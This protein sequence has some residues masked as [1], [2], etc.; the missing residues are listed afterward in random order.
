[1]SIITFKSNEQKETAQT[2]SIAAVATQLAIERNYK[3]L[4]VSTSFKDKTLED[5]FWESSKPMAVEKQVANQKAVE[6][7]SG[8]E[9]L[10]RIVSSGRSNPDIIKTYSR[11]IL[12][13]R[14]DVLPSPTAIDYKDYK[15]IAESYPTILQIANNYYDL[16]FVDLCKKMDLED[17]EN[18][19]QMSDVV[20]VNLTQR[21]K[22]IDNF[23]ELRQKNEFYRK[24]NI[25]LLIGRYD[26]FSK[27]N[28]KNITRYMRERSPVGVVPYNTLYFEACSEAKIIDFF[29]RLKNVDNADRNHMFVKEV[30]KVSNKIIYKI[31]ELQMK[32]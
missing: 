14:L 9:G 19:I 23:I 13:D 18:I 21:L 20:V 10:V 28:E 27:Y 7:G 29:L 30:S 11:V 8:V 15:E 2:L 22:S 26:S 1:M 24:K 25:L 6:V 32:Y 5:C 4:I 12:K 31:Q 16:I 3:I 17:A